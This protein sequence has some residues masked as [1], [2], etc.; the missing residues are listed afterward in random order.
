MDKDKIE[1]YLAKLKGG[2]SSY[3]FGPEALVYKVM[4]KMYA[5]V[6]QKEE[7]PRITLKVNP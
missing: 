2:E 1:E 3:P 4:G 7:T 5:L 6:S